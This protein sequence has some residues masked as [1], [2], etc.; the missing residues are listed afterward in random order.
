M[1]GKRQA[2]RPDRCPDFETLLD[3]LEG[4]LCGEE[5]RGVRAHVESGC[6][7]CHG[8]LEEARRVTDLLGG[9]APPPGPQEAVRRA[10]IEAGKAVLRE[11]GERRIPVHVLALCAVSP[12]LPAGFRGTAATRGVEEYVHR[13][14]P[15]GVRVQV[16]PDFGG[17]RRI[18]GSVY[19]A[20]ESQLV[21]QEAL[22]R[23]A[24][25]KEYTGTLLPRGG[26]R[27][28]ALPEGS[29]TLVL[30][31]PDYSVVFPGLRAGAPTR[32]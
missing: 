25:G 32:P 27:W 13:L 6:P 3:H 10:V 8:V 26:F 17:R 1:P 28:D 2:M 18:R 30:R 9:C 15:V 24:S 23:D 31:F 4:E 21:L 20:A 16:R 29:Y 14:A 22:L 11:R 5:G 7:R 19:P 12:R